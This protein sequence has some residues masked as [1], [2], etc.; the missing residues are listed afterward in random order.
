MLLNSC[1]LLHK[2]PR[3]SSF[4]FLCSNNTFFRTPCAK[5]YAP[6]LSFKGDIGI[7][8][9]PTVLGYLWV[10]FFTVP[11]IRPTLTVGLCTQLLTEV[12]ANPEIFYCSEYFYW[13]LL[14]F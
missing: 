5:I 13:T 14:A 2:V 9:K 12:A 7:I 8:T 3:I 4:Y 1:F 10:L 11:D 6:I